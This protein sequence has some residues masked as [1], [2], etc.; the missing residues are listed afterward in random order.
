MHLIAAAGCP[1]VVM[2]S[3]ESDPALCAPR[4]AD[5][6]ILQRASLDDLD[7]NAVEAA[8]RLR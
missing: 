8:M 2:F 4:G 7:V 3:S 6:E 1:S 5:I